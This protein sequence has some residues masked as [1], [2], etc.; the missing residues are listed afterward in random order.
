MTTPRG[1][2]GRPPTGPGT[3]DADGHI[4]LK[5]D[6]TGRIIAA[7]KTN[8][9]G[10]NPGIVVIAR[11]GAADAVGSWSDHTVANAN[12]NG[13][14]PVLVIDG[15]PDQ[16]GRRVHHHDPTPTTR[17]ITRRTAPLETR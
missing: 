3:G 2:P 10:A 5:N 15:R 12:Q 11:T 1:G 13:T 16:R 8:K 6:G 9:T 14:R 7:V 17:T 4:S